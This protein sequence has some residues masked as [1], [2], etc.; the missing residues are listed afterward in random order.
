MP[1]AFEGNVGTASAGLTEMNALQND[2]SGARGGARCDEAA[3]SAAAP[4]Y[5]FTPRHLTDEEG[6]DVLAQEVLELLERMRVDLN[7]LKSS[8]DLRE[9]TERTM[10]HAAARYLM[11]SR[12]AAEQR[13]A[14]GTPSPQRPLPGSG[15]FFVPM[16]TAPVRSLTLRGDTCAATS[17]PPPPKQLQPSRYR[18]VDTA[19]PWNAST[20]LQGGE[21]GVV[22]KTPDECR[23]VRDRLPPPPPTRVRHQQEIGGDAETL[24][25][26][27][28]SLAWPV[29]LITDGVN[30]DPNTVANVS[31]M[32]DIQVRDFLRRLN[33]VGMELAETEGHI[34]DPVLNGVALRRLV[35]I[36]LKCDGGEANTYSPDFVLKPKTIDDVRL[37]YVTALNMLRGAEKTTSFCIPR[38]CRLIRPESVIVRGDSALLFLLMR[39]VISGFLPTNLEH[40]WAE[41][42][43]TWQPDPL[44]G[45]YAPSAMRSLELAVCSFLF[46]QDVLPDPVA[47]QLPSDDKIVPN[48]LNAPFLSP[49]RRHWCIRREEFPSLYIPSVFPFL[50]NGTTLCD[51]V[52]GLTGSH[53]PVHRNP[54]V[55]L[56]CIEN[57]QS[58]FTELWKYC[59]VRM[60]S[61]FID[62][63]HRVFYG[64]RRYILLLLEDIM[65]LVDGAPPRRHAPRPTDAP[66]LGSRH[67]L[68][69]A[70]GGLPLSPKRPSLVSSSTMPLC[71]PSDSLVRQSVANEEGEPKPRSPE[72][73]TVLRC[74][75]ASPLSASRVANL[76]A[77]HTGIS[78][79]PAPHS[80][81]SVAVSGV[82]SS[83]PLAMLSGL[84][85]TKED[86]ETARGW[87]V[88]VLGSD[89]RYTAADHSF[90][91]SGQDLQLQ[92]PSLV[93]SDGVVLAHLIRTLER[94][95][96][97][98]LES[99]EVRAK[100]AAAKRRNI[101]KCVSFLQTERRILLE[102]PLLDE[103]LFTGDL[104]GVLYVTQCLKNTYRHALRTHIA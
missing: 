81:E 18:P 75:I 80:G 57:I 61:F 101:R 10:S 36:A 72:P 79:D 8:V 6:T 32:D 86:V 29:A 87:L 45:S 21:K 67:L 73:Q 46:S 54:R 83:V 26:A 19:P 99:I 52:E 65:R 38:E 78:T 48:A 77:P 35:A 91:I 11:A 42:A 30:D 22:P 96:C 7:Q 88:A 40:L 69:V 5:T 100:A 74:V 13:K 76:A 97:A 44:Q 17:P 49:Q 15:F 31:R 37:N 60:S 12:W 63:P 102:V 94:R 98:Q 66:Y 3:A 53:I 14:S 70:R 59:P 90:F 84:D 47:H 33:I 62:A 24:N 68:H 25:V 89:F 103:I 56:N 28:A 50:T 92:E 85:F 34:D 39:T 55:K 104:R 43:V 23:T 71:H 20:S 4:G 51:L 64:D 2:G 27:C 41:P 16:A 95:R 58:A 9:S 82:V 1:V 93:F